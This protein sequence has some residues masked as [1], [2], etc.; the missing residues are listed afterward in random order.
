[1]SKPASPRKVGDKEALS[2][3]TQIRCSAQ[4]LNLVAALIRGKKVMLGAIDVSSTTVETP[5]QVADTLRDALA[6]VDADKL[7]P[8]T[9]CGMAPLPRDVALGKLSALSAGAALLR[10]E[11]S[12]NAR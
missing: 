4:K 8:S 1:M 6:F 2:V 10:D 11:L 12:A 7:V 9:N 3:G 5:E